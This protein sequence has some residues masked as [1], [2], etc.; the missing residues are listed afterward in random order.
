[1]LELQFFYNKINVYHWKIYSLCFYLIVF[2]I[3]YYMTH[4]FHLCVILIDEMIIVT[5]NP[6]ANRRI[7]VQA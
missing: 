4:A 7:G 3:L 6:H 5:K 1:M 2:F